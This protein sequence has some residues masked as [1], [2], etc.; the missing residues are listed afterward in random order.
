MTSHTTACLTILGVVLLAQPPRGLGQDPRAKAIW[1]TG[2]AALHRGNQ[3]QAIACF[4]QSLKMDPSFTRPHLSLAA[5][6][7]EMG[8]Q[9]AALPHLTQYVQANPD[10]ALVRVHYAELLVRLHMINEARTQFEQFI[11]QAQDHPEIAPVLLIQSHSKLMELAETAEDDYAEHLNRGIGLYLLACQRAGMPAEDGPMS[12]E[13]LLCRAVQALK[14][15]AEQQPEEARPQWYL[16]LAWSRLEQ[17]SQALR[18]LHEADRTAAF[19]YLT[20]AEEQQIQLACRKLEVH[21][22]CKHCSPR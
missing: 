18:A 10:Q 21:G 8:N 19:S 15:A 14:R 5:A 1:E 2:Q 3:E 17:R 13:G 11:G 4:E 12:T 9:Q 6:Y 22:A 7:M 16:Y 20:A